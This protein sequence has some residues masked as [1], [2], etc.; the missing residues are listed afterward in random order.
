MNTVA[1]LITRRAPAASPGHGVR[2][3]FLA[4]LLLAGVMSASA[5]DYYF[6]STTRQ[7]EQLSGS[8][9]SPLLV[10]GV[11]PV[12]TGGFPGV[13]LADAVE[14]TFNSSLSFAAA[15]RV[16]CRAANR[17]DRRAGEFRRAGGL[18][19]K[20]A[21]AP[22]PVLDF[23]HDFALSGAWPA[24]PGEVGEKAARTNSGDMREAP[25]SPRWAGIRS[26]AARFGFLLGDRNVA[27]PRSRSSPAS[28]LQSPSRTGLTS[29]PPGS[30]R[31]LTIGSMPRTK[32]SPRCSGGPTLE[33]LF[34]VGRL[35]DP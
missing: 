31:R 28:S 9:I 14:F 12:G 35:A 33:N 18:V 7:I 1:H 23:F 16:F 17:C 30:T 21:A 6:N 19:D 13:D 27:A 3:G 20:D 11:A 22:K 15:D 32:R 26:P 8:P 24:S 25:N 34:A 29:R 4:L 5:T 2:A 10:A